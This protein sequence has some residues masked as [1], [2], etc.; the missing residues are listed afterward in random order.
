MELLLYHVSK[1][2]KKKQKDRFWHWD[3]ISGKDEQKRN[4]EHNNTKPS[5]KKTWQEVYIWSK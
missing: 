4:K 5:T 2:P 1:E 3:T